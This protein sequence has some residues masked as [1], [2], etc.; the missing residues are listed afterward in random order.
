MAAEYPAA[1][2]LADP[3]LRA[4][5]EGYQAFQSGQAGDRSITFHSANV[6]NRNGQGATIAITTTSVR[7]NGTQQCSGTV[8]VVKAPPPQ[9]WLL[10]TV[11]INCP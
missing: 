5:L 3:T 7:N 2:A 8:D 10:H 11:D 6:V 9:H 1:W 4:Q